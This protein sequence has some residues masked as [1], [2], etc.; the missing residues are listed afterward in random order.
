MKIIILGAPGSG[1]GTQAV[2]VSEKLGIPHISTGDIFR[3]HIKRG[4]EI[5]LKIKSVID[6]GNLC[7]DELTIEIVRERLAESD[8]EKGYIL[9]GFPRNI[10][11]A[12]ALD[13][14]DAPDKVIELVV[15]LDKIE[16]R[17]TGRRCCL[18]CNSSFHTDF[19]GERKDCP[20]CGGDL[21]VRDDDNPVSV[22][23]RL[24]V[25]KNQTAP[26]IDYYAK[27]GK[28]FPIDADCSVNQV[29]AN[30]LKVVK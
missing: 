30:I 23:E 18:K 11:Q 5:G 27:Q 14:T 19:I 6:G 12:V 22:K 26:L 25:Y 24:V 9:D 8:C 10:T 21:F 15:P 16:K 3:D 1:K 28:L 13:E 4:T 29:F 2:L 20:T 17:I 7:P